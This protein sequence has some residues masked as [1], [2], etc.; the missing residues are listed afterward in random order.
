MLDFLFSFP[1]CW[2]WYKRRPQNC[3]SLWM[4]EKHETFFSACTYSEAKCTKQV[5]SFAEKWQRHKIA[6]CNGVQWREYVQG[7]INWIIDD[8][9]IIAD[10][11]KS[12]IV[13]RNK[14]IRVQ[15]MSAIHVSNNHFNVV[16]Q[17]AHSSQPDRWNWL[18]VSNRFSFR[19]TFK[20][21][22]AQNDLQLSPP[23]R[24]SSQH[25]LFSQQGTLILICYHVKDY[26]IVK[27][28]ISQGQNMYAYDI[29][30]DTLSLN[31]DRKGT[32]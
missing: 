26:F 30:P 15:L 31:R 5:F 10:C 25:N 9:S 20:L 11:N 16:P 4:K 2:L 27:C 21:F 23:K 28:Q 12:I 29:F 13:N 3:I 7:A 19:P 18:K 17:A 1:T 8:K 22:S 24:I 14:S 6:D 32:R